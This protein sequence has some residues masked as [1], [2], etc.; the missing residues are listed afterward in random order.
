MA[1][2]NI[3]KLSNVNLIR[4]G[5]SLI[6]DLDFEVSSGQNWVILG[7]NGSGKTSFVNCLGGKTNLHIHV[8]RIDTINP[9][10]ELLR[11][12]YSQVVS[13]TAPTDHKKLERELE[14]SLQKKFLDFHIFHG[15]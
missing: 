8:D 15:S 5:K 4:N 3:L 6:R 14:T 11:D 1:P 12:I 9:G 7:P 2:E 13:A 10:L